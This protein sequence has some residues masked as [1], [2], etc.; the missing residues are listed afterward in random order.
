MNIIQYNNA[1]QADT[2]YIHP[3]ETNLT[4]RKKRSYKKIAELQKYYQKNPIRFIEQW[5]NIHLIDAQ[6]IMFQMAWTTPN[7]L[8]NCSRGLGKAL[9]LDTPILTPEGYK[10]LGDLKIGDTVYG[11]DGKPTRVIAKSPVWH[12]TC[13]QIDFDDMETIICNEDHLW[14]AYVGGVNY[15]LDTRKLAARFNQNQK[16]EIDLCKPVQFSKKE[17]PIDPYVYGL[18]LGS[19]DIFGF[20]DFDG[21][22]TVMKK[23]ADELRE[24]LEGLGYLVLYRQCSTQRRRVKLAIYNGDGTSFIARLKK[25]GLTEPGYQ[26][27]LYLYSD[28][29]DRKKLLAGIL[30][31]VNDKPMEDTVNIPFDKLF[32]SPEYFEHLV[33]SLGIKKIEVAD[34]VYPYIDQQMQIPMLS[35]LQK[36]FPEQRSVSNSRKRIINIEETI[37]VPTQCIQV[38]SEDGLFLC[39]ISNTVTHNSTIISILLMAKGLLFNNYWT[40]IASGSASQAQQTFTTLERIAN[41]NIEGFKGSTGYIFKQELVVQ[42][43]AGDGFTHSTNGYRYT[44]YNN[45]YTQTLSSNV[46]AARGARGNVIFDEG[47]FL[48][49]ELINVYSAFAI[50]NKSFKTGTSS[51]GGAI[52]SL[53]M[54]TLPK[55][56]PNQLFFI[57]SASTTDSEFYRLYRLFSKRMLMGDR[58]YFVAEFT[59]DVA[60]HPLQGGV[61]LPFPLLEQS[62]VDTAMKTNPEKGLREYYCTFTTDAGDNAI[63]RRAVI[64]RNS[65]IRVPLMC[66][67]TGEKKFILAYDPARFSDNSVIAVGEIYEEDNDYK[68]RI[69]NCVSLVNTESQGKKTNSPTQLQV[70]ALRQLIL[71]YNQGGNSEYSNIYGIYMDRGAGGQGPAIAD[72]MTEDWIDEKGDKHFGLID[73]DNDNYSEN[74]NPNAVKNKI[75]IVEPTRNK[76]LM[77]DAFIELAK[78][79]AIKFTEN[80]DN[81]GEL[82]VPQDPKDPSKVKRVVLDRDQEAALVNIDLM[83][84]QLVNMERIVKENGRDSFEI[85]KEKRHAYHDDHAYVAAMLAYGLQQYRNQ[86]KKS[87]SYFN[88]DELAEL[89]TQTFRPANKKF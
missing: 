34:C 51:S 74:F 33:D 39:G 76:H 65:E 89:L 77:Y 70:N 21:S 75:H 60:V 66:N 25:L 67:D 71:D 28:I 4:E 47:A 45:S 35:R 55:E 48:P 12:N 13:Y 5:F 3:D 10:L 27:N 88:N 72:L 53:E 24:K 81:H 80:Y 61:P 44:L 14:N 50:V 59:F 8:F 30:D 20:R 18:Y 43:A 78:S 69:V 46:D 42:N 1:V 58:N 56:I 26:Q 29:E 86:F 73:Y 41:D 63:I 85:I 19:K 16:F 9:D 2:I 57:S 79:D 36:E 64:T 49:A 54:L 52:D 15:T 84:D 38:D 31:A 23:D 6:K 7:V 37:T 11:A 17:L 62:K 83:K 22:I 68:L 82:L 32:C 40:Y 87:N